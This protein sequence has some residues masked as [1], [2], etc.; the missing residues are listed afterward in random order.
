MNISIKVLVDDKG[1]QVKH[2][3]TI[4]DVGYIIIDRHWIRFG[5]DAKHPN[6]NGW[7]I[8]RKAT[9]YKVIAWEEEDKHEGN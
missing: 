3:I 7:A 9:S 5:K 4:N 6:E 1:H 8:P 2:P